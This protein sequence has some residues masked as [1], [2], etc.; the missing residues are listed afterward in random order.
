MSGLTFNV[1]R[2]ILLIYFFIAG[3]LFYKNK[4]ISYWPIVLPAM[5]FYSIMEGLRW[6]RGTD[7]MY[8]Y[9]IAKTI[10]NSGDIL[11]D[12]I[13]KFLYTNG[14]PFYVFFI[15]ISFTLIFSLFYF[16]EPYKKAFIPTIILVY[17]FTMQQS[18]NLM[19]Q[20]FAISLMLICIRYFIERKYIIALIFYIL[21][22]LSHSSVL[23]IIPF[24]VT[25][26][27]LQNNNILSKL[28]N[29]YLHILL[30]G[31]YLLSIIFKKEFEV[32]IL[33]NLNN[34]TLYSFLKI[35]YVQDSY[36]AKAT[37]VSNYNQNE[38]FSLV[39]KIRTYYRDIVVIFWGFYL[40]LKSDTSKNQILE[41]KLFLPYFLGCMGII[42]LSILPKFEMEVME[43]LALYLQ[44]FI[45]F[46]EGLIIYFLINSSKSYSLKYF[47]GYSLLILEFIWILKPREWGVLGL[48]FIWDI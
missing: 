33:N 34:N 18:E 8:N 11:Y 14:A 9:N 17:G 47:I 43:R 4:N 37:E 38:V 23:F 35:K 36:M 20:Y 1:L 21:A 42:Y 31:I 19:R 26:K 39:D 27:V 29:S 25:Y 2:Y 3:W 28:T 7:Y 16:I 45:F 12:S 32:Y 46:I 40:L 22:F 15:L 41:K 30:L 44:I 13:A 5:I 24:I 10:T 6:K 48:K